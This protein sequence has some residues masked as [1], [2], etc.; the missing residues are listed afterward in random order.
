MN[1]ECIRQSGSMK[2]FSCLPFEQKNKPLKKQA[3]TCRNYKNICKSLAER[4]NFHTVLEILDNPLRDHM[5]YK[6]GPIMHK[7][8]TLSGPHLGENVQLVYAP[9]TIIL[10]G[11]EFRKNLAVALKCHENELFPTYGI[12]KELIST[13]DGLYVLL[14][15][16]DTI[17]YD[18]FFQSYEVHVTTTDKQALTQFFNILHSRF[19]N[20]LDT[21]ASTY[22]GAATIEIIKVIN[23]SITQKQI[24]IE[25]SNLGGISI[26]SCKLLA[27]ATIISPPTTI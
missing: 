9:T 19:G 2:Q 23:I 11:V 26:F 14:R 5:M 22:H 8:E 3:A 7:N 13:D 1:E 17:L 16:C 21:P 27:K 4:Q 15:L 20:L 12:I 25:A 6:S 24:A 18:D 10:N